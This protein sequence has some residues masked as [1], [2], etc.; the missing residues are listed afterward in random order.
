MK[1]KAMES[2]GHAGNHMCA[3]KA[4]REVPNVTGDY[5]ADATI[6]ARKNTDLPDRLNLYI[7]RPRTGSGPLTGYSAY[8]NY[9]GD[10]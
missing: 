8:G 6:M 1:P 10:S 9:H 3:P 5:D 2:I 4:W 7:R